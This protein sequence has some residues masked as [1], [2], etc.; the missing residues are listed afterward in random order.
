MEERK[1]ALLLKGRI[2]IAQNQ[3]DKATQMF[4]KQMKNYPEQED[5]FREYLAFIYESQKLFSLAVKELEKIK[6]PSSFLL[7]KIEKLKERQ[8]NQPGFK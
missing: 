6:T 2:F 5:F 3:F 4:Q 8:R 1:Q 7:K